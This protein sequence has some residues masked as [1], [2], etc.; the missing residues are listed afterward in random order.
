VSRFNHGC[1]DEFFRR[2]RR[3]PIPS[4]CQAKLANVSCAGFNIQTIDLYCGSTDMAVF[5]S[6]LNCLYKHD[7]Q[8]NL[9]M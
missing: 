4:S 3:Y 7:F 8:R 5:D 9:K 2:Y 1:L 6:F